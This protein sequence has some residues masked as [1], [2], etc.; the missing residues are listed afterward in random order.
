MGGAGRSLTVACEGR[1]CVAVGGSQGLPTSLG[2]TFR[3]AG[4]RAVLVGAH[5]KADEHGGP[6]SVTNGI[7]MS[8]LHHA[9][10]DRYLIGVDHYLGIN[11][12]ESV[13]RAHDGPFLASLQ[14]LAGGRL[15]APMQPAARPHTEQPGSDRGNL[16]LGQAL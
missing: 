15:R 11:V 5:I 4:G 16:S 6:A 1:V 10:F 7:C 9:A 12:A 14:A 3:N 8:T 13:I 2:W